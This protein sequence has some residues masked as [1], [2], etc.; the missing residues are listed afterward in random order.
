MFY[1]PGPVPSATLDVERQAK[2]EMATIEVLNGAAQAGIAQKTADYLKA[3]GFNVVSVGN[4]ERYNYDTT[5]IYDYSGHYYTTRWLS[6][7]FKVPAQGIVAL[8]DPNSTVDVRLIVGGD[9]TLP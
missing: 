7:T 4:A 6:E 1:T 9:F 2:E 3:A 5:I 8:R